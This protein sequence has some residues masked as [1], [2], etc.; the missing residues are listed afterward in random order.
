MKAQAGEQTQISSKGCILFH[1]TIH[2]FVYQVPKS[3]H[4]TAPGNHN[5]Q[6]DSLVLRVKNQ[7]QVHS[8]SF[9]PPLD[10]CGHWL[11]SS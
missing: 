3:S 9:S 2:M 7:L 4:H 8:Q 11:W 6:R 5:P 1:L 10:Q